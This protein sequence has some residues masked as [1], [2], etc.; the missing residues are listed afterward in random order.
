[1]TRTGRW[2]AALVGLWLAACSAR[3]Y[4]HYLIEPAPEKNPA[5]E[6]EEGTLVRPLG[7]GS[8]TAMTVRFNDGEVLTEVQI[9]VLASGQRIVIE[10]GQTPEGV[11]TLPASKIVPPKPTLAD[12][13]L[14]DAYRAKGL[15]VNPDVPDVS[16]SEARTQ[17]QAANEAGNPQLALEWAELA[18]ARYP[19]HPEFLRA[20]GSIL[21]LLGEREKAVEVY[22]AAEEIESD[23]QVQQMLE[24][25][26]KEAR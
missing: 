20:K 13:T 1:M 23:P 6:E 8:S 12:K 4:T 19:S 14:V 16:L 2:G 25:L 7:F 11:A 22:E 26:R 21:Y 5:L 24:K 10:H 15:R 17:M 9:P 18:L 3:N